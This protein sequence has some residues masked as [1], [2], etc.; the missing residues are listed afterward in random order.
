[1]ARKAKY[2]GPKP[3]EILVQ[4]LCTLMERD[5]LAPW[6]R[7]WA[8]QSGQH[9]NLLTGHQYRGS[10]P[11]LL[12]LGSMLRG[13]AMP[14]WLGGAEAKGHGWFPRKGSKAVRIIRPQVN[15]REEESPDTGETETRQWVSFKPVCVFNASELVGGDEA[16]QAAL[17]LAIAQALGQGETREPAARLSAA[18]AVL[19]A[20]PV[21]TTWGGAQACYMP[22]ADA[23]AMPPQASFTSREAM[24][25]TWAHEQAH[26]TGHPSRLKRDLGGGFGSREYAREELVA[27][28]ASVLICYRLQVGCQLEGHAAYLKHWAGILREGG[29]RVLFQVLS[30]ARQAADMVAPEPADPA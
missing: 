12:E 1:M 23:I 7:P 9:R 15:R 28:L 13:L 24:V 30:Q 3:D 29:S 2:D 6:R 21:P 22:G 20:W 11:I 27:E 5:E 18:E 25:A 26:S 14:L 16:A 19:E 17:E 10:N 4:D 8:G